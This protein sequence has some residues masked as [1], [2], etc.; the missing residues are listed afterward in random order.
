MVYCVGLTGNIASGKSTV[1]SFFSKL[2]AQIINADQIA[3]ELTAKNQTATLQIIQHFGPSVE[4]G[5]GELDR[6]K[7][8]TLIFSD[9]SAKKW[10]EDLLHP[11]IRQRIEQTIK[12][13]KAPYCLIEIPLLIEKSL[14]PYLNRILVVTSSATSQVERVTKRD[15]CTKEEAQ[16]I[17]NAQA[18]LDEHLEN[19]DDVLLNDSDLDVLEHRIKQL[20]AIYLQEASAS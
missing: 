1:A 11:L 19:A 14:Y 4:L 20:H 2:G 13:S 17:L 9:S 8:R 16:A 10:L 15:N 18:S 12:H 5:T 3:K 6:K 7:L